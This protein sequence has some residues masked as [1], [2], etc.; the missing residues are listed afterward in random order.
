MIEKSSAAKIYEPA[1]P[2]VRT[3]REI[4]CVPDP[5]TRIGAEFAIFR[6]LPTSPSTVSKEDTT[7]PSN[8]SVKVDDV[9]PEGA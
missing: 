1:A 7:V 6:Y 5:D 2:L 4:V 9:V 3:S 8:L